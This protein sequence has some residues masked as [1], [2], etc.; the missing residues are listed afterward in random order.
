MTRPERN[1]AM[2]LGQREV[3]NGAEVTWPEWAPELP[4]MY[5]I[6]ARVQGDAQPT[7]GHSRF[8]HWYVNGS[9]KGTQIY[10]DEIQQLRGFFI[11]DIGT[12][13]PQARRGSWYLCR[14]F[15]AR[16][17]DQAITRS[18]KFIRCK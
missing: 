7:H 2:H 6:I 13:S 15:P 1:R 11:L 10:I 5:R 18:E 9:Y 12:F 8:D 17:R 3:P 4:K 16:V 14:A